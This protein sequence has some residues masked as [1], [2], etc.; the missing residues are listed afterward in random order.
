MKE[1]SF[2]ELIQKLDNH[3]RQLTVVKFI[4]YIWIMSYIVVVPYMI[5]IGLFTDDIGE[6]AFIDNGSLVEALFLA[7]IFAPLLE[8]FI[9]QTLI[10]FILRMFNGIKNKPIVI[11]FISAIIFGISHSYSI[12]YV[13][14]ATIVGVLLAYSYM[15]FLERKESS[16]WVTTAIHFMRNLPLSLLLVLERI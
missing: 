15:V 10:I 9:Y 16:F 4:V 8:T 5:V 13:G 2:M 11:I 6:P 12:F 7:L 1:W 3:L 14:F